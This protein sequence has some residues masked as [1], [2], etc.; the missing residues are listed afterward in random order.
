MNS[1]II[2]ALDKDALRRQ[3]PQIYWP[4]LNLAAVPPGPYTLILFVG[5]KDEV[6]LSRPVQ[7]ALA[8]APEDTQIVAAGN[9]FTVEAREVLAAARAFVVAL[10]DFHWTDAS[11]VR[12]HTS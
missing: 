1:K 7:K 2:A 11:Y 9:G 5:A 3:L 4:R 8:S 6:V 12:V 10:G